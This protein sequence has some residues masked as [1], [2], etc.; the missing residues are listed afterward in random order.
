MK[1]NKLIALKS[2]ILLIMFTVLCGIIYPLAMT[3]IS[4]LAFHEKANGSII[5][6]DGVK[7]GSSLLGQQFTSNKYLWGRVMN[8]NTEVFTNEEGKPIMYAGP[9]NLSPAS[10]EYESLIA[11]RVKKIKDAHPYQK[12]SPIPVDL[13]TVSGSGLDPHISPVAAKYQ[14]KRIADARN[15]KVSKVEQVIDQYTSGKFLGIFGQDTVNVL[16]VNL[17]LDGILKY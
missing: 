3:G 16:K 15:I 6:I 10:D 9:S 4:Q 12:D 5:E 11:Q 8:I 17:A 14:I 13:V 7:Y 1:N 2:F